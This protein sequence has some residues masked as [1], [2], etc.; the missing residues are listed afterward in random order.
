MGNR[1]TQTNQPNVQF[2]NPEVAN[3]ANEVKA[4]QPTNTT[5]PQGGGGQAL[6]SIIQNPDFQKALLNFGT[7]AMQLSSQPGVSTMSG[8][9]QA[10]A[11]GANVYEESKKTRKKEAKEEEAW[12]LN[13][14][15]IELSVKASEFNLNSLERQKRDKELELAASN[16]INA[17]IAEGKNDKE[18]MAAISNKYPD[19]DVFGTYRNIKTNSNQLKLL[20]KQIANIDTQAALEKE[21]LALMGEQVRN[22]QANEQYQRGLQERQFQLNKQLATEDKQTIPMINPSTG[23]VLN[24]P[25][26]NYNSY[27]KSG[28]KQATAEQVGKY[29]RTVSAGKGNIFEIPNGGG[30]TPEQRME[31]D[32]LNK[33]K[34]KTPQQK[35]DEK[36]TLKMEKKRLKK[37]LETATASRAVDIKIKLNEINRE[38]SEL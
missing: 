34:N 22:A 18:I 12:T 20:E 3:I 24:V 29:N 23:V 5:M 36:Y 28:W 32:A 35:K 1:N 30:L 13:K 38:I 19:I 21:R 14:K 8:I 26:K 9:G 16:D 11:S 37:E 2:Q 4:S 27:S 31:R 7:T 33:K 17:M 25:S 10:L 15:N 6:L